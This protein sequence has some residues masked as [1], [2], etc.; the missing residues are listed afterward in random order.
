MTRQGYTYTQANVQLRLRVWL[1][2]GQSC[3]HTQFAG[4]FGDSR[5]LLVSTFPDIVGRLVRC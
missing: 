3:G 5:T 2:K 1:T 4:G